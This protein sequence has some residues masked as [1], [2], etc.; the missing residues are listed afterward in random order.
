M[1][2]L[3]LEW[4]FRLATLWLMALDSVY[5]TSHIRSDTALS[6]RG[7]EPGNHCMWCMWTTESG[8]CASRWLPDYLFTQEYKANATLITLG[9]HIYIQHT[10]RNS[11]IHHCTYLDLI[12]SWVVQYEE[13][14]LRWDG[15]VPF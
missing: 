5:S 15:S 3:N 2:L 8:T 7:G 13:G 14:C 4:H 10:T 11:C 12:L 9:E 6:L 1:Q